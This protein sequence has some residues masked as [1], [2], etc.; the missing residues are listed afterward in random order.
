LTYIGQA[1]ISIVEP[2]TARIRVNRTKPVKPYLQLNITNCGELLH[3]T[4]QPML[5]ILKKKPMLKIHSRN[6]K[7]YL[8]NLGSQ[9]FNKMKIDLGQLNYIFLVELTT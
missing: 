6:V 5:Q 8:K 4:N 1:G 3:L 7:Y 9:T 2:A